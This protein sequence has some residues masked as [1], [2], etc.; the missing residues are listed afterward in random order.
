MYLLEISINPGAPLGG[1]ISEYFPGSFNGTHFTAVDSAARISDFG[2][3]NYAGQYF[4]G[5]PGSQKQVSMAWA[6]NWQYT[7][8]VPTASSQECPQEEQ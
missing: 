2:K 1:S 3:D 4:Y 7:N 5:I 8:R 6:S